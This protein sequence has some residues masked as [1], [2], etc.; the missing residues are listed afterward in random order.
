MFKAARESENIKEIIHPALFNS[1]TATCRNRNFAIH[2]KRAN[3]EFID[4]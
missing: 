4:G 1:S 3:E 2:R